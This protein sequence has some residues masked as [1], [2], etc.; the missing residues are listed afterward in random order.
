MW[1]EEEEEE[2]S[3]LYH[4]HLRVMQACKSPLSLRFNRESYAYVRIEVGFRSC[5]RLRSIPLHRPFV[6]EE[7]CPNN[8]ASY[9]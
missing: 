7:S 9:L 8:A 1:D 6:V 5:E 4:R 2:V 3:L